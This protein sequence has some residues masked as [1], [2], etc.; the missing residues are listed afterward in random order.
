MFEVE[1]V[2]KTYVP[3]AATTSKIFFALQSLANIH[4]LYQFSLSFFMETI[5]NVLNK[6]EILSKIPKNDLQKRRTTIF[7]EIFV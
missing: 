6:N 5:Y 3:L 2:T 7:N 4:F 1:S